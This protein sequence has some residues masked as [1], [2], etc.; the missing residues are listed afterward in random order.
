MG[1]LLEAFGLDL[2]LF[3][4]QLVNFGLLLALLTYFLYKPIMRTIDERRDLM[5][6]GVADAQ[7]A[8]IA[9]AE[10][11]E[12]AKAT[13][14]AADAEA[15]SVVA[16]ARAEAAAEKSRLEHEAQARAE[17]IVAEGEARARDAQE[18]A[19]RESEKEIARLALLAAAKAMQAKS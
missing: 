15:G 16:R 11:D 6:K 19:L 8:A 1:P 12:K 18:R 3:I 4:A 2:K 5:A 9:A 13:V 17:A 10:A 7:A 14:Q